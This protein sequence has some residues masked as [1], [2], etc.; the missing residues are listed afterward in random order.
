MILARPLALALVLVLVLALPCPRVAEAKLV[1]V[2]RSEV[3]GLVKRR[4]TL[5][6]A[7]PCKGAYA[8]D[9]EVRRS[10]RRLLPGDVLRAKEQPERLR[11]LRLIV[12]ARDGAA[13]RVRLKCLSRH[14][15]DYSYRGKGSFAAFYANLL[16]DL[17][18][19][20]AW[21]VELSKKHGF[22]IP[23]TDPETRRAHDDWQRSSAILDQLRWVRAQFFSMAHS[24]RSERT[25]L[26]READWITRRGE[27]FIRGYAGAAPPET[28]EK[29]KK[30]YLL[31]NRLG[32]VRTACARVWRTQQEI[33]KLAASDKY[34][35]L[36]PGHRARLLSE[37]TAKLH[38][39]QARW[40]TKVHTTVVEVRTALMGL[41]IRV[42]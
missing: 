25:V 7:R 10:R 2:L 38:T 15:P 17:P 42:R 24:G 12:T 30:I 28:K 14:R 35:G 18:R 27:A 19:L 20:M 4:A 33:D 26:R 36:D 32:S 13:F 31:L 29:L 22:K 34:K 39:E 16:R 11:P 41:G 21:Y 23:V 37:D 3:A 5:Y 40:R 6:V 9:E 8:L 1:P